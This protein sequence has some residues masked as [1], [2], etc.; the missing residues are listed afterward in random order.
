MG[1]QQSSMQCVNN[2]SKCA[3][4]TP[5]TYQEYIQYVNT[6]PKD[7]TELDRQNKIK[8]NVCGS[9]NGNVVQCCNKNGENAN[10]LTNPPKFIKKGVDA[11]GN[12]TD[13][14]VCNCTTDE[15]RKINCPDFVQATNYELCK[16]R[17]S[18]EDKLIKVD[19]YINKIN[20][21]D[22]YIDCFNVC[23]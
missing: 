18:Q 4:T 16:A 3:Y 14:Q 6:L 5:I 13:Y 11:Y 21:T 2:D 20:I 22:A 9:Y 15:C 7:M 8:T 23:K 17:V 12:I 10:K 19:Q 1:L